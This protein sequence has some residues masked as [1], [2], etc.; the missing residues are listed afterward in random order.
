MALQFSNHVVGGIDVPRYLFVGSELSPNVS[1]EE[2]TTGVS[3]TAVIAREEDET[4]PFGDYVLT[5]EDDNAAA[6]EYAEVTIDTGAA[7]AGKRFIV[8]AWARN[9]D[10]E[11]DLN[12][13]CVFQGLTGTHEKQFIVDQTWWQR[14][15]HEVVV[16]AGAAGNSLTYRIYPF[17]KV[18]GNAG[19]GKVRIDQFRCR[20]ILDEITMPL[21]TPGGERQMWRRENQSE[22]NLING[23]NR[24][25]RLGMRYF[26]EANYHERPLTAAQEV[27]RSKIINSQNDILL[28]PH[29]DSATCYLVKWDR[30]YERSWGF[31]IAPFGHAGDVYVQGLELLPE[32]PIEVIDELNE[33]TFEEE[34]YFEQMG[35]GFVFTS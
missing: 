5:V 8:T 7:I 17:A 12:L 32:L 11:G 13:W 6:Q 28:F 31:G 4:S 27:N 2:N 16:P 19:E 15:V 9:D 22:A 25:Y 29:Q 14:I 1:F 21:P 18:Q 35:D 26:Y 20:E 23:Q 10:D 24:E 34:W 30:E 3:G 33:Y